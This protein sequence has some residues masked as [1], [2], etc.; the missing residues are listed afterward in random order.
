[1]M[2]P[3]LAHS[4]KEILKE[5]DS[6]FKQGKF[7]EALKLYNI[8]DRIQDD[9]KA[10]F[11]RGLCNY[12]LNSMSNAKSDLSMAYRLG[13]RNEDILYYLGRTFH[14]SKEYVKA[15]EFYKLYLAKIGSGHERRHLVIDYI[16]RCAY[17]LDHFHDDSR[18]FVENL[19]SVVNTRYDEINAIQSPNDKNKFY[20]SSNRIGSTGGL[21]DQDGL[22]DD[23]NGSYKFD[24]FFS[25]TENGIWSYPEALN[26]LI[27]SSR[28]DL[29]L[30]FNRD[31]TIM[32][33]SKFFFSE[34]S[35]IFTDTFRVAEEID[36]YPEPMISPV[37][38]ELGDGHLTIFNDSTFVF[39]SRR[40]GG[41]GGYDL[42]TVGH[43]NGSWTEVLNLGPAINT[44][45]D[46]ISASV[47]N[48][49]K[50]LS[51]SSD[52]REGH[53]GFDVF[54]V[55]Y[56]SSSKSWSAVKNM[57][58]PINSPEDDI[59]FRLSSD[60]M[61]ATFS[62]DRKIGEGG[63]D[64][65]ITYLNT[66][67]KAQ[68][69]DNTSLPFYDDAFQ[70]LLI[71]STQSDSMVIEDVVVVADNVPRREVILSP[72]LYGD[73]DNVLT[74]QNIFE[75]NKLKDILYIYP[76]L[77]LRFY[78]HCIQEGMAPFDLYFSMKRVEK[79]K[80]YMVNQGINPRRIELT[81]CGSNYPLVKSQFGGNA[82]SLAEKLNRRIDASIIDVS[83]LP[84]NPIDKDLS[85]ASYLREEGDARLKKAIKGLSYR[86]QVVSTKQMYQNRLI[87]E[88]KDVLI[89]SINDLYAYTI[90][91]FSTYQTAYNQQERL[92]EKG[93]EGLEIIPY[94]DGERIPSDRLIEYA[95]SYPD[96]L[97]FLQ[98]R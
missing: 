84:I 58:L 66:Q 79:I 10:I 40:K 47:S 71:A 77:R 2:A 80:N 48:D 85:I 5:A 24:I 25:T 82:V 90:G 52:R 15:V 68:L 87:T 83:S 61:T 57:G 29:I 45:S 51:F 69:V 36:I 95:Q 86:V 92:K 17:G 33:Y 30:D 22:K 75:L 67:A 6:Y 4:Q 26:P 94:F 60:G 42:Y 46:E 53:G 49:G 44:A 39:S 50:I 9:M 72:L 91:L 56:D 12:N 37:V 19:G 43:R 70:E 31:G 27:N 38:G 65:Y 89:E 78:S 59:D 98:Q 8:Y 18:G 23:V 21:R 7:Y 97:V 20:F 35:T 11:R 74:P 62:S 76:E 64:L 34:E 55:M 3:S 13:N 93:Y 32:Y 41:Y 63:Y 14:V 96:L 88:Q 73:D 81:A 54:E 28:N 16:K 1:M